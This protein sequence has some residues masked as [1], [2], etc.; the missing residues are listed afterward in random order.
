MLTSGSLLPFYSLRSKSIDWQQ[1]AFSKLLKEV[2]AASVFRR[3]W[4]SSRGLISSLLLVGSSTTKLVSLFSFFWIYGS[5]ILIDYWCA[6]TA[7]L[8]FKSFKRS[9]YLPFASRSFY[10]SAISLQTRAKT[11]CSLRYISRSIKTALVFFLGPLKPL[12]CNFR[13]V[14]RKLGSISSSWAVR[15]HA[16]RDQRYLMERVGGC[17]LK[18]RIWLCIHLASFCITNTVL[19]LVLVL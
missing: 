11:A 16:F 9:V 7:T 3:D 5:T 13:P 12:S 18:N 17:R 19:V 14:N 8:L 15:A 4:A 2:F 1:S 10:A 6:K